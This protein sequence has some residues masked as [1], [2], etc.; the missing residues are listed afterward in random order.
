MLEQNSGIVDQ[1]TGSLDAIPEGVIAVAVYALGSLIALWCWYGIVKKWPKPLG[2][3]TWG[4]LFAIL[5]TPTVSMG[6]NASL[7]PAAFGLIF[8]ILTKDMPLVW[9]N[10]ALIACVTAFSWLIGYCWSWYRNQQNKKTDQHT[11]APL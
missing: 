11:S 10:A 8:G 4:L 9:N 6:N 3:M 7:A 2:G 5:L 1:L